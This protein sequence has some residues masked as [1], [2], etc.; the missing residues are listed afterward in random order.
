[1]DRLGVA[2][3]TF[4]PIPFT[5]MGEV[6]RVAD[7]LGYE[8]VYASE[9]LT[10]SLTCATWIAS[11]T[12]RIV[13]GSSVALVY[14]RHP[15]IAAQAATTIGDV[16][17]GRFVLGLGLG[18]EPRNR[19]LGVSFGKPL[20]DMRRYVTTVRDLLE[21]R[22]AYPDL[23]MQTYQGERLT[24]RRP[25][26]PVPIMMAASGPRMTELAGELA[27]RVSLSFAPLASMPAVRALVDS[28]AR[29]AGRDPAAVQ[30]DLMVHAV[31]D[32]DLGKAREAA[33]AALAYWVG[34]PQFNLAV[35][36]AGF[37][38][39]AKRIREAF[40]RGDQAGIRASTTDAVVDAFALVGPRSRIRDQM[41]ALRAG[42]LDVPVLMA[43][44]IDPDEG[45]RASL[46]RTLSALA[47]S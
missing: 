45:Y 34:L 47:P 2:I 12:E 30:I 9:S 40:L 28:G 32:E 35:R 3:V 5:E 19:A 27:D 20:G 18:H 31:V 33:R 6:A 43:D 25:Q 21:G 41:D 4:A 8:R 10:D 15:L 11:Q 37:P 26:Q 22:T 44:P 23:P 13:V 42:G 38:E 7:S 39:E 24:I 14:Y 1:M 16:S 46:E 29:R 36:D 17:G